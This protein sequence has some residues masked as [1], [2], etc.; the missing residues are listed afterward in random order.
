MF[1]TA[2]LLAAL[3]ALFLVCGYLIGGNSGMIIALV[4]AGVGNLLAFWHS[5][6]MILSIQGARLLDRRSHSDLLDRVAA[7]AAHAGLPTPKT[8]LIE[9]DQPNAFATGRNPERAAVAVT[10]GLLKAL[11]REELDGVI[12]HELAH[13]QN[14]DT[15]IMTIAAALGG[16]IS[17]LAMIGFW[18]GGRRNGPLG[19]MGTLLI[20]F[21]APLTASIIQM[22]ISRRREY[23]ADRRGAA[24]CGQPLWLAQALERLESLAGR[25]VNHRAET[26]PAMAHLFI[27]NPLTRGGVDRLFSTH[28]PITSRVAALRLL[29]PGAPGTMTRP[30]G[31]KSPPGISRIPLSNNAAGTNATSKT[32]VPISDRHR[33]PRRSRVPRAG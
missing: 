31:A 7:L 13:I 27:V 16:A 8:Y 5:D 10:S 21:L 4:M 19:L 32:S 20:V 2:I 17:A 28:P 26:H 6:K 15:L 9:T 18:F 25:T 22:A 11:S 12:A 30:G 24:I 14:R 33:R 23:E 29:V 1:R 3:S